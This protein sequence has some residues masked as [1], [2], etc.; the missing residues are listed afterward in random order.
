MSMAKLQTEYIDLGDLRMAY[1][2]TGSGRVLLLLHGNSG[3]KHNFKD[4]QLKH[5]PMFQ[6]IAL[7]SRGHGQSQSQD[8]QLTYL[9]LSQDVIHFCE[10]RGIQQ[11]NVIG[12]SDGGNIAILLAHQAPQMFPH[13]VAISPNY[14]V[15]G[16]TEST[17][18]LFVR[19]IKLLT[20]LGKIGFNVKKP[21]LRFDLMMHDIGISEEELQSIRTDI[22]I[23]Y[24]ENDMIKEA[25]IQRLA[26]L[27][28]HASLHKIKGCNHLTILN[29]LEAIGFIKS[30]FL[31]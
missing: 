30:Y 29:K 27:I 4:Y 26:K 8:E 3:S 1:H 5:F 23:L 19:I 6:T 14:L 17:L 12:Y 18:R 31:G 2:Q 20:F 7:D 10:A 9:Q 24:A 22:T 11:A 13:L 28:P 15:T 25:H 21:L 16:T